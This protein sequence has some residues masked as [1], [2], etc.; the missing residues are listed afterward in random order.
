MARIFSFTWLYPSLLNIYPSESQ[1]NPCLHEEIKTRMRWPTLGL[2][3][4]VPR[5]SC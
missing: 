4:G 3:A 1:A 2:E 5:V